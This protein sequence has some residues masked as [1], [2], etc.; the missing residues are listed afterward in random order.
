MSGSSTGSSEISVEKNPSPGTCLPN[1]PRHTVSG[2]A[3][4]IPNGPHS[5][6]QN[7]TPISSATCEM[8][9]TP[10]Y[11]TVSNTRFVISSSTANS[12]STRNGLVQPA[13][14]SETS[15]GTT[16]ATVAPT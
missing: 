14:A 3:S 7:A 15:S 11:K 16:A 1:T 13:S 5:Q 6:P 4:R 12:A 10:A 8:P 9:A 2:V